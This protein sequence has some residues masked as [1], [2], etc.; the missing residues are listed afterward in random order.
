[1]RPLIGVPCLAGIGGK[2]NGPI[3]YNN[4]SYIHAVERAGGVPVLIPVLD[5]LS[6]LDTLLPR[7]D[8]LLLSGGI[9]IDP[10]YYHEEPHPLLGETNPHLDELELTL[11]KWAL[12]HDLPMMGICRGMQLINVALGGTLYQDLNA[13]Y[14]GCLRH[15]NWDLARNKVVHQM[16]IKP[17]SIMEKVLATSEL[18][19][20]SLHH[21]A[22]KKL[23]KGI[24]LSGFSEDGLPEALEVPSQRFVLAVQCHPEELYSD[25]PSWARYFE[26]FIDVC[27]QEADEKLKTVVPH[28]LSVANL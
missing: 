27:E 26:A 25:D 12:Q 15:A 20:N 2:S 21:Q 9:D 4:R 5:N 11:T 24:V 22:V 8:G 7:L 28:L 6:G 18:G 19:V 17:G 13:E 16:S 10:R 1:M 3:Y 14:S 23:G